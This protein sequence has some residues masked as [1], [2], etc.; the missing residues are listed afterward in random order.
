MNNPTSGPDWWVQRH[1]RSWPEARSRTTTSSRVAS[2]ALVAAVG[3]NGRDD[4]G[5]DRLRVTPVHGDACNLLD[6]S[7]G[8]LTRAGCTTTAVIDRRAV[9]GD[10]ERRQTMGL[11]DISVE[12]SEDA[13]GT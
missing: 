6:G 5:G 8:A 13:A 12:R 11:V 3:T 1:A 2:H 4:S 9:G 10:S 7:S